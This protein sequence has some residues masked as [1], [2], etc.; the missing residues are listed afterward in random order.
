MQ[1][2]KIIWGLAILAL[3]LAFGCAGNTPSP[4]VQTTP[5]RSQ[6]PSEPAALPSNGY[7]AELNLAEPPAKMRSGQKETVRVKIKNASD[8]MWWAKGAAVNTR[9]DNKFYI[10]AG[11][12]WLKA[13]GSLLT[14]MDGRYGI[15]KDL[16]PGEETEVPLQVTAPKDPGEYTLEIDLLQEG[17]AWFSEKGS[18]T[19]KVKVTVV[20]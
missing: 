13:D 15:N 16:K 20:K 14:N 11:N 3:A 6:T 1:R 10:A 18:A 8:V 12:R 17:V 9:P 2:N 4:V 5:S 7:K 19:A